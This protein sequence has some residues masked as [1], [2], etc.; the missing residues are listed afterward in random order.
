MTATCI[1]HFG[2]PKT[3]TTAIQFSLFHGLDDPAFRYVSPGHWQAGMFLETL[4]SSHPEDYWL[5]R[6]RRYSRPRLRWIRWT[7]TARFRRILA[8]ARDAGCTPVISSE[9][10]WIAPAADLER[11]RDFLHEHGFEA[12]VVIYVRPIKSW[13]ESCFQEQAKWHGISAASFPEVWNT[14]ETRHHRCAERLT[15]FERVFG[16]E[17]L[18]VRPFVR[19]MLDEGC[20]V[21]DFCRVAG[22]RFPP[23]RV[24][25][26][27]ES[28]SIDGVKFLY[29]YDEFRPDRRIAPLFTPGRRL[30]VTC[31]EGLPGAPFHFH[32]DAVAP[33]QDVITFET[34]AMRERYGID[35]GEDLRAADG[36]PCLRERADLFRYSQ[37]SLEWLAEI[38]GSK[39]MRTCEG[40]AA[41]REVATRMARIRRRPVWPVRRR[42]IERVAGI[43][44]QRL[45]NG[46]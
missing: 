11:L 34:R 26:S 15:E 33:I 19:S 43:S 36:G 1:L 39:P 20:V 22:I 35:I 29:A 13:I 3:G 30:L 17:N 9:R 18:T 21:R 32:S 31:L 6:L 40:E 14:G 41:A 38:S 42:V 25:R 23:E 24:M 27:N 45:R 28:I 5:F 46:G 4:F 8:Q 37:A 7:N 16:R 12:R 10:W 2:M 44:L